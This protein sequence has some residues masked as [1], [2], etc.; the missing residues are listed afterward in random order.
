[1]IHLAY[2]ALY[3]LTCLGG[4]VLGRLAAD[5]HQGGSIPPPAARGPAEKV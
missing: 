2:L 1:M 5:R 4:V 3:A